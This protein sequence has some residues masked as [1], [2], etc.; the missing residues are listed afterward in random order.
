MRIVLWILLL[1]GLAFVVSRYHAR[2]LSDAREERDT[3]RREFQSNEALPDGYGHAIV[4]QKSGAPLIENATPVPTPPPRRIVTATPPKPTDGGGGQPTQGTVTHV[5]ASGESLGKICAAH[6][7]TG[8]SD[9]VAA[10]AVFNK[11]A[12]VDAIR[13]GQKIALPPLSALKLEQR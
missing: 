12:S 11:I 7:G 5:V 9:V 3:R 10:V 4:G 2:F 13:E 8:R 6:Y 1:L